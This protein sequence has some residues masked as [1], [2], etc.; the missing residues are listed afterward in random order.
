MRH[1][2]RIDYRKRTIKR[3]WH[4]NFKGLSDLLAVISFIA[5]IF[6]TS[7]GFFMTMIG[8]YSAVLDLAIGFML[9]MASSDLWQYGRR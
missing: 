8:N 3:W 4:R 9:L 6:L 5:G 2:T 7:T 1:Y